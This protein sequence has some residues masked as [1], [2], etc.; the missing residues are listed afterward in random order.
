MFR[1]VGLPR[2]LQGSLFL[3]SMP[4]RYE[5]LDQTFAE[6]EKLGISW[7]ICLAPLDEI[8]FKPPAYSAAIAA[9]RLPWVHEVFPVTDYSTPDDHIGFFV[10]AK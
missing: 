6:V 3:H 7:V 1:R 9:S 8:A 10:L 5:P 4:G 2:E